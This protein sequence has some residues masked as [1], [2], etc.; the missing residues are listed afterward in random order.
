MFP[1]SSKPF[2]PIVV[3]TAIVV[4]MHVSFGGSRILLSLYALALGGTPFLIGMVV[5]L[6]ALTPMFVSVPAGRMADRVGHRIPM[7]YGGIAC[8]LGLGVPFVW[9]GLPALFI[10]AAVVGAGFSFFNIAAQAFVGTV[11]APERR[12]FNFST[13]SMGY[14]LASLIGPLV[15]GYSVEYLGAI[16]AYA[17]LT[18]VIVPPTALLAVRK[19]FPV[20][21]KSAT[22]RAEKHSV[23]DL[24]RNRGLLAIFAA[25]GACVAGWDLFSFFMPIY[26]TRIG[27][28]ASTIG[29]VI[30]AFGVAT[31]VI[32]IFLPR[33]T[34]RHGES[35]VLAWAMCVGAGAF[36]A[37]PLFE[38][39]AALIVAA[40]VMG[41][42]L[43]CGQPLT[44]MI[45]YNR[46][47]SGRAGEANGLRQM[48]NNVTHMVIPLVFGALGSAIGMGPVFWA[49]SAVLVAGALAAGK[50]F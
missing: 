49:N 28:S 30:S 41:L 34:K 21:V 23:L 22:A 2:D 31:L 18:A 33:M 5:A 12:A 1:A 9:P 45:T 42:G 39:V 26:G 14:S 25:S 6:Y 38:H 19:L 24:L 15:V 36:A 50:R 10:S 46:S 3:L 32:R 8:V 29:I 27:M 37:V 11:S 40:F 13:L 43:G 17:I 47:P 4:A 16:W 44:M 48:A 20:V 35:K 7:L